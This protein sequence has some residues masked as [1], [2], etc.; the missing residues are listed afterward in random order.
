MKDIDENFASF[1]KLNNIFEQ[2]LAFDTDLGKRL[3]TKVENGDPLS[4]DD[5]YFLKRTIATFYKINKKLLD[6]GKIYNTGT[7]ANSIAKENTN[8]DTTPQIKSHL[9]YLTAHLQVLD[10]IVKVHDL[11][12]QS[13]GIFR[14]IT[15]K[16]L[17]DKDQ[18]DSKI[19][20]DLVKMSE[21]IINIGNKKS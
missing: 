9:I 3:L 6:F 15:K 13:S 19:I 2:F 11:Y 7:L 18:N 21:Y 1:V 12:Y 20:K 17:K 4:G 10:H 16:A 8:T 14:R 5:L